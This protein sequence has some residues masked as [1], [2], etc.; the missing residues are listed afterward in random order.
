MLLFES[1]WV[2]FPVLI[3]LRDPEQLLVA[4]EIGGSS[5]YFK[6]CSSTP[7]TLHSA[8]QYTFV[9]HHCEVSKSKTCI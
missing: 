5:S 6:R 8:Q 7:T 2:N 9:I 3:T 4:Q 1:N